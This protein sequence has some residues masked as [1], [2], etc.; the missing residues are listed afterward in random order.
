MYFFNAH[1]QTQ[2]LADDKQAVWRG[3]AKR[4]AQDIEIVALTQSV[5]FYLIKS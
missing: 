4:A 3:G 1:A 5:N 2:R